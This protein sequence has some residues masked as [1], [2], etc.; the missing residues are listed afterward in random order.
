M[1]AANRLAGL[2]SLKA[3]YGGATGPA[4]LLAA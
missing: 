4:Q 1:L 2:S 3:H